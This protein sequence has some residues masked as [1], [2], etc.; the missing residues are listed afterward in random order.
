MKKLEGKTPGQRAY[1]HAIKNNKLVF[2]L[3]PA[4]SG[5]TAISSRFAISELLPPRNAYGRII[6]TRPLIQAGENTGFLPG[7]IGAKMDPFVRPIYDELKAYVDCKELRKF[8]EEGLIEIVPFAYMRG[9]NF[10][11]AII[12]AD[13]AQNA[14][15]E[16]LKMLITRIGRG[17]KMIVNGD[18]SQSDLPFRQRGALQS[19]ATV[20]SHLNDVETVYLSGEDIVREP[21][22]A[23]IVEVLEHLPERT[24]CEAVPI[25]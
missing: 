18:S 20:L 14:T 15:F 13:E 24:S 19:Y 5:K 23:E 11:N 10:H 6:I 8:L 17:S 12:V 7:D 1:I 3:G 2:C 25:P 4:G 21:L 16:Q 9:R 22:V